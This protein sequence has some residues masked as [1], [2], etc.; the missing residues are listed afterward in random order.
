MQVSFFDLPSVALTHPYRSDYSFT[1]YDGAVLPVTITGL[2]PGGEFVPLY[3]T[4]SSYTWI[5]DVAAGTN[6]IFFMIDSQGRQGGVSPLNTVQPLSNTSCLNVNSP[7]STASA[8]SQTSSQSTPSGN[9]TTTVGIIAGATVGGLVL[10]VV[11]IILGI[12]CI[13]RASRSSVTNRYSDAD[14]EVKQNFA[15]QHH[16]LMQPGSPSHL[17]NMSANDS[18][19]QHLRQGSYTG[20]FARSSSISSPNT[21]PRQPLPVGLARP[22]N[23]GTHTY[24]THASAGGVA[25]N[26]PYAPFSPIQQSSG[27]NSNL[28]TFAGYGD[29][30][31]SSI[32]SA[33]RR[34]AG[35]TAT[36]NYTFQYQTHPVRSPASPNQPGALSHQ[37]SADRFTVSDPPSPLPTQPSRLSSD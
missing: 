34:M 6:L 33:S 29:A 13:R 9:N 8:P 11:L 14:Y 32:A 3:A 15:S 23:P 20:S 35:Q 7:S 19:N 10:L 5:A 27:L 17:V 24:L 30:G 12:F 1:T 16:P 2:I 18:F 26:D 25:F 31:S 28:D 21:S 37:A 36:Q 4:G 22:I